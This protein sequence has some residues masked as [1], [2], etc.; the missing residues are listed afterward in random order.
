[1]WLYRVNQTLGPL[2]GLYWRLG[3]RG[4]LRGIPSEGPLLVASNHTSFLDPWFIGMAFP[5]PIRYLITSKWYYRGTGWNAVFRAFGTVPVRTGNPRAT[6]QTVCRYLKHGDAFGIFPEGKISH[7]GSLG[8]FR[9]GLPRI[10]ARSGAPVL[11]VGIRGAYRSYP[12]HARVPRPSPVKIHV[13]TVMHFEG[14]PTDT[15]PSAEAIRA[16]N[17][18]LRA[19]IVALTDETSV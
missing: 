13:G 15:T 5:R 3:L 4:D 16:F 1:M 7:D 9:S 8:R 11:P 14:S 18:E 12:R 19:R 10:A 2:I 17:Q 6:L